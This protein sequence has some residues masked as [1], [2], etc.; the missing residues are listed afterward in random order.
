MLLGL[1]ALALPTVVFAD[2]VTVIPV[3][4]PSFETLPSG[5]LDVDCG[6]GCHFSR[7]AIPGWSGGDGQLRP[8]VGH[9]GLFDTFAPRDGRTSAYSN[10]GAISQQ[11]GATVQDGLIYTLTL[12][13]G[14]RNDVAFAGSA[15]LLVGGRRFMA[16]GATPRPGHWSTFTAT[17]VGTS[18]NAGDSITI[19]LNSS[20]VQG[21][22]DSVKLTAS[23]VPEPGTLSMLG[24]GL[25][26]LAGLVRRRF[27][28]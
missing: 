27:K 20:G 3:D 24:V 14:R 16:T 4:N 23:P 9:D 26:G 22:F 21:N 28:L 6:H 18:A 19:Q 17:F 7:A 13:I 25:I 12:E 15:D 10:G 11:V 2:S 8:S 5:G 1:L